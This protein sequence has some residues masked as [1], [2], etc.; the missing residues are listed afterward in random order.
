MPNRPPR[1]EAFQKYDRPLYFI[2]FNAHRRRKLLANQAVHEQFVSFAKTALDRGIAVGRYVIMPDHVHF[3]VC[4]PDDFSLD[5]WVRVLKRTL[6][7][8]ISAARPHWQKGFFDH[9]IRHSES[10]SEK[11][12]YVWQNPVRAGLVGEPNGWPWQGEIERIEAL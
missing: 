1:L 2:T 12:E 3:F 4:G 8:A 11:W 9:L 6:S 7:E 5:Q 10:Y